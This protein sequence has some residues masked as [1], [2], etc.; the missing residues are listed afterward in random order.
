MPFNT[1]DAPGKV[2]DIVFLT[3][4]RADFSSHFLLQILTLGKTEYDFKIKRPRLFIN[5]S[6]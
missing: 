6:L 3:A 1:F 4:F 2:A 5:L